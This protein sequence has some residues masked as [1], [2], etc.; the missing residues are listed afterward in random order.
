[1]PWF[2]SLHD[3]QTKKSLLQENSIILNLTQGKRC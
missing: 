3:Y 2:L 1:M